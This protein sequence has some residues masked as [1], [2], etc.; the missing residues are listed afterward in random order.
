LRGG[1]GTS[2]GPFVETPIIGK[3]WSK[4]PYEAG[5]KLKSY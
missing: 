3:G 4:R 2:Q 1:L 5:I